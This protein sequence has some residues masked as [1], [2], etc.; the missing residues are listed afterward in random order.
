MQHYH[1]PYMAAFCPG[2]YSPHPPIIRKR[3]KPIA[4]VLAILFFLFV[5][6]IGW[7]FFWLPIVAMQENYARCYSC[8]VER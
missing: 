6:V 3:T 5:P 8:G 4:Y 1:T 7:L 2:C